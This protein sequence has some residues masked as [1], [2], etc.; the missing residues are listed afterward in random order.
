MLSNIITFSKKAESLP[1]LSLMMQT[2]LYFLPP[3]STSSRQLLS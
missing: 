3:A 2:Q 1:N